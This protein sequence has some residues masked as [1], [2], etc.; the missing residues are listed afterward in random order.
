MLDVRWD[1]P[2]ELLGVQIVRITLQ[3]LIEN[4]I[5][6]GVKP[7]RKGTIAI[8]AESGRKTLTVAVVDDGV[9]ID[10]GKAETLNR[11]FEEEYATTSE[12]I[13]LANVNQRTKLVFGEEYG[14]HVERAVPCGTRVTMTLP[15][16]SQPHL[17]L[18]KPAENPTHR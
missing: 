4:A 11:A 18:Q 16:A 9:G 10:P 3:P 2:E 1:I 7:R 5:Y 8:R 6:H 13:G 12:H 14:L 17:E 15:R